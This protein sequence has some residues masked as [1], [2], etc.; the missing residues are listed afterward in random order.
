M[1]REPRIISWCGASTRRRYLKTMLISRGF[2]TAS[3]KM[4]Q[5]G[6]APFTRE[7]LMTITSAR[8]VST[9]PK[10][11]VTET[12]PADIKLY[13]PGTDKWITDNPWIMNIVLA[14]EEK[15][16]I[17]FLALTPDKAGTYTLS[18][19]VGYMDNGSYT[20]YQT[21]IQDI[22]VSEDTAS[23]VLDV[24]SGL[25]TLQVSKKDASRVKEAGKHME[26]VRSRKADDQEAIEKNIHDTLEAV[27]DLLQISSADTTNIRLLMDALLRI[28]EGRWYY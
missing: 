9:S 4:S 27:S 26:K 7:F 1:C 19:E 14:P 2:S 6:K 8:Q 10:L 3:A 25:N 28:W 17:H 12:Y 24:L 22:V 18:T 23:T 5:K 11:K 13:D 15:K 16:I 21:M 20:F